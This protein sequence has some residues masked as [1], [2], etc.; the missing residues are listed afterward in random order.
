[1][2]NKLQKKAV[3]IAV[4]I[5]SDSN[6]NKKEHKKL[7]TYQG[8]KEEVKRMYVGTEGSCGTSGN[9]HT[10]GQDLQTGRM[11]SADPGNYNRGLC[12]EERSCRTI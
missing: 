2:V 3:M 1:M 11:A 6:I 9:R 8:L 10:Q 5:P 12:P 7:E 4:A